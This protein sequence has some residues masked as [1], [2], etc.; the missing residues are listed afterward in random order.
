MKRTLVLNPVRIFNPLPL[1]RIIKDSQDEIEILEDMSVVIENGKI[2][3]LINSGRAEREMGD[4]NIIDCSGKAILPGY[5]DSHTHLVYS[6]DRS[7]EFEMRSRGVSYLEL[8]QSGN[9]ILRTLESTRKASLSQLVN[10]SMK[11][12]KRH[13][14]NGTTTMEIKTGYGLDYKNEKKM[15]DAM[16]KLEKLTRVKIVK[17]L[18]PLHAVPK[19]QGRNEYLELCQDRIIPDLWKRSDFID[20]FC[21]NGAFTVEETRNFFRECMKYGRKFRLH[22]D[23]L[24]NIGASL[25]TEEFPIISIDHLLHSKMRDIK[26]AFKNGA[27]PTILPGTAL[28]LGENYPRVDEWLNEGIPVGV[29]SDISPLSP[30]PDMKFHG[31]LAIK[32]CGMTPKEA[33]NGMTSISSHSLDLDKKKGQIAAGFDADILISDV[34]EVRDTFYN[35]AN[36]EFTVILNGQVHDF[37]KT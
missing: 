23:E 10:Q 9:G 12:L 21:D 34:K 1:D 32:Y 11:R 19:D 22:A 3:E 2:R 24:E 6:G 36:T 20:S 17:T 13:L 16:Y 31:F 25:L 30:V 18:L 8:L 28:S 29:A 15:L 14:E 26:R 5:V 37:K 35:W 4:Y 7:E 27:I 33:F